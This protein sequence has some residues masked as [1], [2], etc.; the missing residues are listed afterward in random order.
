MRIELKVRLF[1]LQNYHETSL[2]GWET[3]K[4]A[5]RHWHLQIIRKQIAF[6][7]LTSNAMR[8]KIMAYKGI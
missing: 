2:Y 7:G 5:C 6:C 3:Y 8:R 4:L 1:P